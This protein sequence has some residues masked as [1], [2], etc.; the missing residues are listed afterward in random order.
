[1]KENL[2]I[3]IDFAEKIKEIRGTL[4]IILFGSV[5]RGEDKGLI[6][7]SSGPVCEDEKYIK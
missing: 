6:L 3:A 4:Q 2:K 5:A 1:M 7:D